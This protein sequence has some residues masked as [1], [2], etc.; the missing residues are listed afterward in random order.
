MDAAVHRN[1]ILLQSWA[2]AA[3]V[4]FAAARVHA[5]AQARCWNPDAGGKQLISEQ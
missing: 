4:Q 5:G 3:L 1:Y 2:R